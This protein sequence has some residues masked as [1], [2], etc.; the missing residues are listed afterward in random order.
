MVFALRDPAETLVSLV[1]SL[2]GQQRWNLVF[3]REHLND[4]E[5]LCIFVSFVLC[6]SQSVFWNDTEKISMSLRKC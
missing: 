5:H 2:S 6:L 4:P 3:V 1:S